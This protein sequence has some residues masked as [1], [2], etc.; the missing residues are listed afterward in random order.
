M[1]SKEGYNR[2]LLLVIIL[3][4]V[5]AVV[6]G[7]IFVSF[8]T[9]Y[10]N[11]APYKTSIELRAN[12]KELKVNNIS[13]GSIELAENLSATR[14]TI[15]IYS[16][17][18]LLGEFSIENN[19]IT[20]LN[21]ALSNIIITSGTHLLA[22]VYNNE[23]LGYIKVE[24]NEFKEITPVVEEDDIS[25]VLE[26]EEVIHEE[27]ED[28]EEEKIPVED[29]KEE[30]VV[31]TREI[32]VEEDI[33]FLVEEQ[34]E[35]NMLR[36]SE[37]IVQEGQKG[38]KNVTYKVRYEND[39]EVSRS[40]VSEE[41]ITE[42]VTQIVKVGTSDYNLNDEINI[43]YKTGNYCLTENVDS[44]TQECLEEI[45]S[46]T[47]YEINNTSKLVCLGNECDTS[48][49]NLDEFIPATKHEYGYY[50]TYQGKQLYFYTYSGVV[51]P[52]EQ[53]DCDALNLACGIW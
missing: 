28:D 13:N 52:L 26:E 39:K 8:K 53:A 38:T 2:V 41:V 25:D 29:E 30:V 33:D 16:N 32:V 31:K 6:A 44:E 47:V 4:L 37:E 15:W 11:V 18:E 24:I 7:T 34:Q 46:F 40:K 27:V 19:T 23:V 21:E 45:G 12:S 35:V 20:G 43:Y 1:K 14:V 51:K 10:R 5:G 42:P 49:I 3:V 9:H 17:P 36:G 50:A 48:T 22:L